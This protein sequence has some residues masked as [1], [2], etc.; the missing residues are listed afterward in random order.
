MKFEDWDDYVPVNDLVEKPKTI[1]NNIIELKKDDN[2]DFIGISKENFD[3]LFDRTSESDYFDE[4][5]IRFRKIETFSDVELFESNKNEDLF[6]LRK[7]KK[8]YL[9]YIYQSNQYYID[10]NKLTF[11]GWDYNII[12]N[13]D[14]MSHNEK[15]IR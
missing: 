14:D 2:I 1:N 6:I 3:E 4:E 13:L 5:I 9:T 12:V 15:N 8:L 7:S 10:D 11:T